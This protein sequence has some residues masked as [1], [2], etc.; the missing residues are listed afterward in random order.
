[1]TVY[2]LYR[3]DR[4]LLPLQKSSDLS[5][6]GIVLGLLG[7]HTVKQSYTQP[8]DLHSLFRDK[9]SFEQQRNHSYPMTTMRFEGVENYFP[10]L[11]E[12]VVAPGPGPPWWCNDPLQPVV[13]GLIASPPIRDHVQ[14]DVP[15]VL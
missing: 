2:L 11:S 3:G 4:I 13:R 8:H 5:A 7:S 10:G 9:K 1:M 15:S 14:N 12:S 6:F